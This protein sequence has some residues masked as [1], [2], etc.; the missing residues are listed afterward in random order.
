[1]ASEQIGSGGLAPTNVRRCGF[2]ADEVKSVMAVLPWV[3]V[4]CLGIFWM[5]Q[6]MFQNA[7]NDYR[8]AT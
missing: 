8:F 3:N 5:L 1:M 2:V 4:D 7:T 6:E